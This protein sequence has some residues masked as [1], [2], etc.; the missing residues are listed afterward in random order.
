MPPS[1]TL[2]SIREQSY[3][4]QLVEVIVADGTSNDDTRDRARSVG[5]P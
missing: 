2:R 1:S 3:P 5:V 4:Q